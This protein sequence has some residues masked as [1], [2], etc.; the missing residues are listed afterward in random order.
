MNKTPAKWQWD[1]VR[2]FLALAREGSLSAAA[3]ML[4][5]G[6]VTV[7]RRITLLEQHLGVKLVSRT[8]DGFAITPGGQA[9]LRQ[10]TVMEGAAMDLERVAAGRDSLTAG[11]VR[12]TAPEAIARRVVVP[13]IASLREHHPDL[14]IDLVTSVRSLDIARREADLAVRFAR[15]SSL[16]LICRRLGEVGYSLYASRRYLSRRD[17]PIRGKGLAGHDLIT[18]TATPPATTPF[19]MGE[20]LDGARTAVRCDNPLIQMGAAVKGAGIAEL[21]CFLGDDSSDL[22]RIWPDEQPI[23]RPVWLIVHQDL[24]RSARIRA[25]SAAIVEACRNEA[26]VLRQGLC[27]RK[28]LQPAP[29]KSSKIQRREP[30]GR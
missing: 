30:P 16:D 14:Q 5:V 1:D 26:A 28:R 11:T 19:F 20:S 12:L 24:R 4:D 25:V 29:R 8:P 17:T 9:I 6:H 23:L 18:F 13:A 10:S 22:I 7:A 21:A 3:R 2:F 15:P 27:L